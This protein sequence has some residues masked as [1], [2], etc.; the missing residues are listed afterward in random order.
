[1]APNAVSTP[2][3]KTG[4]WAIWSLHAGGRTYLTDRA[5]NV[6]GTEQDGSIWHAWAPV[7]P[8]QRPAAATRQVGRGCGAAQSSDR[9]DA[10]ARSTHPKSKV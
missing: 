3:L 4:L 6:R 7:A 1:M 9:G 2:G 5:R 8:Q 10:P